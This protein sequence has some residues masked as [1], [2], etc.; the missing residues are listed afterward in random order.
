MTGLRAWEPSWD[1]VQHPSL[2]PASGCLPGNG[3][4]SCGQVGARRGEQ[5]WERQPQRVLSFASPPAR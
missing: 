4:G 5:G 3:V 2:P 1:T